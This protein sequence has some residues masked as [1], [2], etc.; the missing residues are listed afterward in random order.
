MMAVGGDIKAI[1]INGQTYP[2]ASDSSV[3]ISGGIKNEVQSNGDGST[4]L[5]VT[6][7]P[8]TMS[9]LKISLGEDGTFE[10]LTKVKELAKYVTIVLTKF[11]GAT[12][13]AQGTIVDDL[14]EDTKTLTAEVTLS[15]GGR[16]T[17][18]TAN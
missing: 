1:K 11:D 14:S 2:V 3:T 10:N 5:L 8:W 7:T 9:G 4:R 12:L 17:P 16:P 15:G 18:K 13:T 6:N